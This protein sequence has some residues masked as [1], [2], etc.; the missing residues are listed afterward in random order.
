[1]IVVEK[2]HLSELGK[3]VMDALLNNKM[4]FKEFLAIAGNYLD[5][6][7]KFPYL[8]TIHLNSKD[9]FFKVTRNDGE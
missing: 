8:K 3:E 9:Y 5:K 4:D 1:M 6:K 7:Q 2:R